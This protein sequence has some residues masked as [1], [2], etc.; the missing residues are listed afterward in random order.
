[1][2]ARYLPQSS[3]PDLA[4]LERMRQL[5][6]AELTQAPVPRPWWRD[7]ALLG[8]INV[9]VALVC[10][11]AL[12]AKGLVLNLSPGAVVAAVALPVVVVLLFGAVISVMPRRRG[13]S[14]ASG[15][16]AL[17]ALGAG[18]LLIVT[19]SGF[20]EPQRDFWAVGL[21]CLAIEVIISLVPV[22][23]A[24]VVLCGFAHNPWRMFVGGLAAGAAGIF[25]LH[26]H[27]PIGTWLHLAAFHVL[28]WLLV[29][30]GAV[31]VRGRMRSRSFA[32]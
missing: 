2:S 27:C 21:T 16:S 6:L 5:A 10:T 15:L 17:V 23:T 14:L 22:A 8:G 28:P 20:D 11:V 3:S 32:P 26:L 13:R 30:A 29:A 24:V 31:L 4:A 25:A 7:A 19:G 18:A 9:V 1:M 12:G